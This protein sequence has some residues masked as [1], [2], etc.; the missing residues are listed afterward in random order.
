MKK[1]IFLSIGITFLASGIANAAG[2]DLSVS[3]ASN[4]FDISSKSIT[5]T[6]QHTIP[7]GRYVVSLKSTA[8]YCGSNCPVPKV[9]IY[10]TTNNSQQGWF[11]QIE[12][13]RPSVIDV[14]GIG[15][16]ANTV[17]AFY[18]DILCSDNLGGGVL[19]FKTVNP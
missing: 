4:C 14:S 9:T 11:N 5:D 2:F 1:V 3:A 16:D 6:A 8:T 15:L 12:A 18:T 13:N 19:S 10:I 7:K 17:Y